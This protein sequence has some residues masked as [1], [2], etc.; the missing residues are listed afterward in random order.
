MQGAA[1]PQKSSVQCAIL[2]QII[3]FSL[4]LSTALFLPQILLDR[5]LSICGRNR[6]EI[7]RKERNGMTLNENRLSGER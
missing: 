4:L 6:A 3:P 5:S 1:I 2:F 7:S